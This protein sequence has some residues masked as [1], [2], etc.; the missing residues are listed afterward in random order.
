MFM[1]DLDGRVQLALHVA[2]LA[3]RFLQRTRVEAAVLSDLIERGQVEDPA[4]IDKLEHMA[5]KIHGS[6]TTF[7]YSAVSESAGE[8]EHLVACLKTRDVS[9]EAAIEP[10][11][12]ERL[13]KCARRLTQEVEA[14]S[15]R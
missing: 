2:Q 13:R 3:V 7:G 1:D 9:Q 5:H 8:I 4:V 12:L 15:A 10:Q 14:A 11:M 6:G